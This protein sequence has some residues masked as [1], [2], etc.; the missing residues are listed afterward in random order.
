MGIEFF[1]WRVRVS[2]II[3]WLG[4]KIQISVAKKQRH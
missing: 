1:V 2:L 3:Y 4:A